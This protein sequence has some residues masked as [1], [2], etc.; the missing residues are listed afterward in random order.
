VESSVEIKTPDRWGE[1]P[2]VGVLLRGAGG[3]SF[4]DSCKLV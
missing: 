4:L 3:N 1:R 2:G